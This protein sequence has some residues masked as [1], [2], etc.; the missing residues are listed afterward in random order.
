MAGKKLILVLG[1]TGAQGAAVIDA[2]L[3]PSAD[4][5]P[6]P[7]AVRAL[8]RNTNSQRAQTLKDRGVECVQGSFEDFP[9][10][11]KALENVYGAWIN[12]DG[13]TVGETRELYAGMRIFELAKQVGT[14]RHY[15]WSN[16][17]YTTKKSGYNPIHKVGHYDGKG[18]VAE[19]MKAQESDTSE[20]GMTWSSVTS[21]PY[22]DMLKIMMFGPLTRRADGTAIFASP[23][24]DGHVAMIALSDLGFFARY[25]F[26]H[27]A[28][29]SGK[30][31]EVASQMVHWDGPDGLVETFKRVTGQKAVFVRQTVDQWMDN[32][33]DTDERPAAADISVETGGTSWRKNF[34]G[35]WNIWRDDIVTRDM[36]WIRSIHPNVN[37]LES[38][39]RE[40]NYT[41][42]FDRS[43]LKSIETFGL[44][45]YN[46][47]VIDTL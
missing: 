14:V 24:G 2:L 20:N 16:L 45:S 11:L 21:G 30:D 34:S 15:I 29:V 28:E 3:A 7:Y 8:T 19:W 33:T 9:T 25:S 22:M 43:T 39:M 27:R 42:D 32:F 47:K 40:N 46:T 10:V 35:F 41:G 6:S 4:G 5:S 36:D 31:L 12:T 17:D 13:F 26:D 18:R 37:T 44:L 1:A 23:I 38:W